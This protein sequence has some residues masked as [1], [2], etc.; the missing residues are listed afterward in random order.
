MDD[1]G[2]SYLQSVLHGF[3]LLESLIW[4]QR[5]FVRLVMKVGVLFWRIVFSPGTC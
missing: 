5:L 4:D 3:N 2:H 1:G